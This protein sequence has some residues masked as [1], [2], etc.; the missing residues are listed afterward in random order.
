MHLVGAFYHNNLDLEKNNLASISLI[1][2]KD[3]T[4]DVRN[5]H[6]ISLINCSLYHK[7]FN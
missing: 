2:K 4:T 6:P 7:V 3:N 1:P 5:F